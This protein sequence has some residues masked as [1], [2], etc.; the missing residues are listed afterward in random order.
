METNWLAEGVP[1]LA[2]VLDGSGLG[3]I[4]VASRAFDRNRRRHASGK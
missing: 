1:A 2:L 4:W 3:Y